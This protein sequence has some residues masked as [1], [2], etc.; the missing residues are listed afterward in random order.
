MDIV[1]SRTVDIIH[2]IWI[3]LLFAFPFSFMFWS[4]YR[5]RKIGIYPIV[6]SWIVCCTQIITSIFWMGHCPL[7][8]IVNRLNQHQ[9]VSLLLWLQPPITLLTVILLSHFF[10]N[11]LKRKLED[12]QITLG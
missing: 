12:V 2:N 7:T 5:N 4:L 11:Y 6:M 8:Q 3:V 10:G 9:S 1:L